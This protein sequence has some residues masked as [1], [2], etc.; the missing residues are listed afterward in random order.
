MPQKPCIHQRL[1]KVLRSGIQMKRSPVYAWVA[2]K[3]GL[4]AKLDPNT[5]REYQFSRLREMLDFV[6]ASQQALRRQPEA[7]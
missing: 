5:L 6:I 1:K 7:S 2:Q 4:G 3:T